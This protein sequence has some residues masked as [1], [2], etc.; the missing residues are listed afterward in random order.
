MKLFDLLTCVVSC[1]IIKISPIQVKRSLKWSNVLKQRSMSGISKKL[2]TK[3]NYHSKLFNKS[4]IICNDFGLLFGGL[5]VHTRSKG[6]LKKVNLP[7]FPN[8]TNSCFIST[9]LKLI[10]NS[11][12]C[13]LNRGCLNYER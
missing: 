9:S 5:P 7:G 11:G 8:Q 3:L 10:L 12:L 6:R 4:H 13:A 2:S 1:N